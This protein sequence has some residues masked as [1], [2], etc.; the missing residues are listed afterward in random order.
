M[1]TIQTQ[2]AVVAKSE[3]VEAG[4]LRGKV[5]NIKETGTPTTIPG[6][7]YGACNFYIENSRDYV[8]GHP[9]TT[10]VYIHFMPYIYL[11]IFL[12]S[13]FSPLYSFIWQLFV[14]C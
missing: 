4:V 7:I 12:A 10:Y 5:L 13:L 2:S 6:N 8:G 14:S 9:L 3:D 11:I 1:A